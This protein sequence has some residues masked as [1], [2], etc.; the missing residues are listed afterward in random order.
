MK[1]FP[2]FNSAL[3]PV[4]SGKDRHLLRNFNFMN[5][6]QPPSVLTLAE[7]LGFVVELRS[8]P[9]SVS[10]YLEADVTAKKG[11]RVVINKWHNVV[12]RRFTV[13]HE[14]AHFYLHPQYSDPLAPT[15]YRAETGSI[16]H[17]YLDEDLAEEREAN[18]W[19]EAIVFEQEA[20]NAAKAIHG[21][22]HR[23]IARKF[24]VSREALRIVLIRR[25]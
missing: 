25:K 2:T 18:S 15:A 16:E 3:E 17:F 8:L 24:G 9:R 7:N 22:D 21:D 1:R 20:L 10:G 4:A 6:G 5:D 19:V 11:F 13:L 14:I 12:R 23:S